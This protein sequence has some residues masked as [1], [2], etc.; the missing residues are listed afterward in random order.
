MKL[1]W[2][3]DIVEWDNYPNASCT[4][5]IWNDKLIY[6]YAACVPDKTNNKGRLATKITVWEIDIKSRSTKSRFITFSY[7]EVFIEGH[8]LG[9][10]WLSDF[11]KFITKG[12]K[13]FLDI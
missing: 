7:D 2:S 9:I 11:W 10:L 12:E 3:K 13:L 4:P 8:Y 5:I 1:L 6:A